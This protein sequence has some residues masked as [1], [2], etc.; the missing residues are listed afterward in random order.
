MLAEAGGGE[1]ARRPYEGSANR[2]LKLRHGNLW[3]W[4]RLL[5]L[6]IR[7]TAILG[8]GWGLVQD[9]PLGRRISCCG[10]DS[11]L[12]SPCRAYGGG[13]NRCGGVRSRTGRGRD[14]LRHCG[15][16]ARSDCRRCAESW[17]RLKGRVKSQQQ[18]DVQTH[19]KPDPNQCEQR[20]QE[21]CGGLPSFRRCLAGRLADHRGDRG[22]SRRFGSSR[23]HPSGEYV[24]LRLQPGEL[25]TGL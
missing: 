19:Q 23:P 14:R 11:P 25:V 17:L 6:W 13:N 7:G 15:A 5:F 9:L 2:G 8:A 18:G 24:Y 4:L 22:E 10:I 12:V 21:R 3:F 20:H 16:W 1:A